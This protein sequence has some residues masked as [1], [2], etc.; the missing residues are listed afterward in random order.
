MSS[1]SDHGAS[2]LTYYCL[3]IYP[4]AIPRID[5]DIL[6]LMDEF[7]FDIFLKEITDVIGDSEKSMAYITE[8]SAILVERFLVSL[9]NIHL[10]CECA[11][12]S[13]LILVP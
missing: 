9:R 8:R 6:N 2:I 1:F 5:N 10:M 3:S 12:V 11:C 13:A 4:A 7:D